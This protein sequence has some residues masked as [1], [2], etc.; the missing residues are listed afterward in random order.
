VSVEYPGF[1]DIEDV[2]DGITVERESE[3]CTSSRWVS[4]KGGST[5]RPQRS[6]C[7]ASRERARELGILA[8]LSRDLA[9]NQ[10]LQANLEFSRAIMTAEPRLTR[11]GLAR[12][13]GASRAW[14][15]RVLADDRAG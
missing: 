13:L 11:A 10:K 2:L 12:R 7:C 9:L 3:P 1:L 4:P 15:T 8:R 5:S 14:I 6:G